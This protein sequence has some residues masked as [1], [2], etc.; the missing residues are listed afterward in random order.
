[1]THSIIYKKKLIMLFYRLFF[2]I[3]DSDKTSTKI[4]EEMNKMKYPGEVSFM[5]LNRLEVGRLRF[6]DTTQVS[7]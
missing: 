6:P 7:S 4:L 2:Y 5:P 3:V 1:M